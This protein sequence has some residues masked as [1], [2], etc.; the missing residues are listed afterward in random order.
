MTRRSV[1]ASARSI[2]QCLHIMYCVLPSP[3]LP[4]L[5]SPLPYSAFTLP[6]PALLLSHQVLSSQTLSCQT[7]RPCCPALCPLPPPA[8]CCTP[9]P[10]YLALGCQALLKK[11]CFPCNMV[12]HFTLVLS[13]AAT[14][15]TSLATIQKEGALH[16]VC[17]NMQLAV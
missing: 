16:S 12:S 8:L 14:A 2:Q 3:V 1:T 9:D 17:P 13:L 6:C 4:C 11:H 10:A 5:L 7:L 15:N